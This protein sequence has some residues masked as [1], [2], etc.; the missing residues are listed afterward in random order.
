MKNRAG[1][2]IILCSFAVICSSW[3][4][5]AIFGRFTDQT[6]HE[7]RLLA[8]LPKFTIENYETY[9]GSW[10]AYI[11]DNIP[12]RNE[13]IKTY[14]AIDYYIFKRAI[15]SNVIV[16]KAGWLFYL[17]NNDGYSKDDYL[18]KNLFSDE[19]LKKIEENCTAFQ[20]TLEEQ[21]KEFI[22]FIAPN[23]ERIYSEYMPD[24][25]G[26]PADIYRTLQVVQYLRENTDIKVVYPYE[27]LMRAKEKLGV[28]LYY[29]TDTH[30][31]QVGGYIGACALLRE[32]GID[33]PDINSK[34]INIKK[35]ELSDGD[36]SE[37]LGWGGKNIN[38]F[39]EGYDR[40][41][42]ENLQWDFKTVIKYC[43]Q[44]SDARKIFVIR[45]SFC[46]NMAEYIGSQFS[47][48]C[49]TYKYHYWFNDLVE[50]NPDVVV[51]E[52]VERYIGGLQDFKWNKQK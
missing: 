44:E 32:L 27:E 29:K 38:Y 15:D 26:K 42:V 5:W 24:Q 21:G 9:A 50:Y 25:Y 20:K 4:L 28:D 40:H 23:K 47:S 19:D 3:I 49:M 17:N 10:N 31:N 51:L 11:D 1:N 8:E 33:M 36:L 6:N 43:T 16:G 2:V 52:T 41:S 39:V 18:G 46:S 22:L 7:K 35:T 48:S 34:Q 37:M 14:S 12:F 30:W 13:L 45:D